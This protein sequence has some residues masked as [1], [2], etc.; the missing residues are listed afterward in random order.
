MI[1]NRERQ[2]GTKNRRKNW[3]INQDFQ[4]KFITYTLLPVGITILIFW[5]SIE[6]FFYRMLMIGKKFNIPDNHGFYL[7]LRTQKSEFFSIAIILIIILIIAFFIWGVLLSHKIAGPFYK[8]KKY[9]DES[10]NT[11]ECLQTPLAFRKGDFF[12]EIPE[13]FNNFIERNKKD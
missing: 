3:I 10:Q 4:Y 8:F 5:L 1:K 11:K 7:L 9:L 6:I 2:M 13:A 12:L